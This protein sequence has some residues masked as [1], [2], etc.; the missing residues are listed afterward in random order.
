MGSCYLCGSDTTHSN[1]C[2]KYFYGSEQDG[3]LGTLFHISNK[4]DN[5]VIYKAKGKT[6]RMLKVHNDE[7][8][9]LWATHGWMLVSNSDSVTNDDLSIEELA[10]NWRDEQSKESSDGY[11]VAWRLA[12]RGYPPG[13]KLKAQSPATLLVFALIAEDGV[14]DK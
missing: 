14:R 13:T 12:A 10:I 2:P 1:D 3:L 11:P 8:I 9:P 7:I 4:V 6:W 5:T